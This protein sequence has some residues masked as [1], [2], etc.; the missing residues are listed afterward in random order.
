[1]GTGT[2]DFAR[3]LAEKDQSGMEYCLVEQD[4]TFDLDPL[5]AIKISHEG[6]KKFGFN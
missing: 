4:N 5:E 1:V 3:I 2:I 6:L